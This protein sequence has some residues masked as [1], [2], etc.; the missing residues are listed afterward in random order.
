VAPAELRAARHQALHL[1]QREEAR[2]RGHVLLTDRELT[3]LPGREDA[4]GEGARRRGRVRARRGV[5]AEEPDAGR[6]R[7]LRRGRGLRA[8][9]VQ[10][11]TVDPRVRALDLAQ[12]ADD[13]ELQKRR[14]LQDL[15]GALLVLGARAGELHDDAVVALLLDHRLGH[16]ELVDPRADHRQRPV[17]RVLALR[18]RHRAGRVVHF[19]R[20]V[21]AALQVQPQRHDAAALLVVAVQKPPAQ[22]RQRRDQREARTQSIEHRI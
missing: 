11:R 2:D 5:L 17:G 18:G 13:L 20:E 4:R 14:A 22:E 7:A 10:D 19:Q 1:R 21:R 9:R 3:G 12:R 8:E 15:A 16:A 6:L